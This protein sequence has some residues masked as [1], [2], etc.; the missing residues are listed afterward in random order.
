MS[1]QADQKVRGMLSKRRLPLAA[2]VAAAAAVSM[3]AASSSHADETP[4]STAGTA[5]AE[6]AGG[7]EVPGTG[8]ELIA[9]LTAL[10]PQELEI[11]DSSGSGLDESPDSSAWLVAEDGSG[12]TTFDLSVHRWATEDW[13]DIAGC[14][15][16][17]EVEEGFTCEETVLPDGSILS[18]V[19]WEFVEEGDAEEGFEP[20]HD[21]SWEVWLEGPGGEGLDEPGGRTV[22][23]S[24]NKDL[25]DVADPDAHT[26]LLSQEQLTDVVLSPVW[27][28][29]LDA[30]DEQYGPPEDWEG[31]PPS[32]IPAAEL[33]SVFRSLA[34]EGLEITD[35][36]D[37][38]LG[39]A[40]LTVD[41]GEGPALVEITAFDAGF[42]ES[43]GEIA[44][45]SLAG[46][47]LHA[48]LPVD[49]FDGAIGHEVIIDEVIDE[50]WAADEA[51][52][53]PRCEDSVLDDGTE[54]S[55]CDW[56]ASAEDSTAI[57][58]AVIT[59]PNG[60]SIDITAYNTADWDSEPT[61]GDAVLSADELA[62]IVVADEWRAFFS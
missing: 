32:E 4:L 41:D 5:G 38:E 43:F 18:Y 59:Y 10:L 20:Y 14:Q 46:E 57:S 26:P 8:E 36:S 12:G 19:T 58:W 9:T 62:E 24:E 61:R 45:G 28:Q 31:G 60:A 7:A 40:S 17:G 11:T 37:D 15:G 49:E 53:E 55:V 27:Q 35:G 47:E 54:L 16:F 44:E 25:T 13:H 21:K 29:V 30:A 23:L 51:L 52:D 2:A 50:E 42:D 48:V 3:V 22:L 6:Q 56:P 33:R 34:P 1:E 39:S